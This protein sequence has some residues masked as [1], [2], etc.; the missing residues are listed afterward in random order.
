M[1]LLNGGGIGGVTPQHFDDR[2]D[3][4]QESMDELVTDVS[5]QV[6]EMQTAVNNAPAG[7]TPPS[8]LSFKAVSEASGIKLS[9]S[10]HAGMFM[11]GNLYTNGKD[12]TQNI[13]VLTKGVMV[14]YRNDHFPTSIN[15]GTL[16]FIDEED[17]FT[18]N[19]TGN[20]HSETKTK[21]VVGLTSN[22]TYYFTAFP[23]S[24]YNVYNESISKFDVVSCQ[25]TGTAA[26]LTVTIT[27]N[28][29]ALSLG[30]I[31]ATLTP[32]AGGSAKSQSRTG[33]GDVVFSGVTAGQYTLS[34]SAVDGFKSPTSQQIT[35]IA[36]QPNTKTVQYSINVPLSTTSWELIE[37]I[38]QNGAASKMWSVGD[39]K[40]VLVNGETLTFEIVG[41]NHDDL[42][43][44]SGKAKITF[45]MKH[46]M[47]N[48][49]KMN[50]TDTSN[51]SYAGSKMNTYVG[52]TFYNGMPSD[53][54]K[55]IKP[56]NKITYKSSNVSQGTRVDSFKTWL[57]SEYE[58]FGRVIQ[59]GGAEGNQYSRFVTNSGSRIKKMANGSG[60]ADDWWL[61]SPRS[62]Y[63]AYFC[64]VNNDG[65]AD[66]GYAGW[67]T[68]HGVCVGFCI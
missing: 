16:A 19:S 57:F 51:G 64:R 26:T 14:R 56:V 30:E 38:S 13:A 18:I 55:I 61:R 8:M 24:T 58:V 10:V 22:E 27:Q 41:F 7:I 3:E 32:T 62:K 25:W 67:S 6:D 34:F 4:L 53:L 63:S 2:I 9:Y 47:A 5:E 65:T 52:T 37:K 31:T 20:K 21:V 48:N 59:S 50:D 11:D 43:D 15:D 54:K 17:L 12:A 68:G 46:L 28:S 29:T 1:P 66:A 36:G 23:Y 39:T 35:L 44:D 60:N 49:Q 33:P 40:D 42:S 45:G